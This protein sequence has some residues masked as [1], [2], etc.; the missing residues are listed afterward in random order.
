M[1]V[2]EAATALRVST[3]TIRRM[4]ARGKLFVASA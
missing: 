4:I 3:K 1:T 2:V